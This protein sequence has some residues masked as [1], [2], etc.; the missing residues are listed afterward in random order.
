MRAAIRFMPELPL[1]EELPSWLDA[2]TAFR[3]LRNEFGVVFFDSALRHDTLGRYSFVS[4][5]PGCIM[6]IS[7]HATE[8]E[9]S[10]QSLA[11]FARNRP[12]TAVAGL[13]PFQ[14]GYIALL[15]YEL[16]GSIERVPAATNN[17]FA[18]PVAAI[19]S[20]DVVLAY[21]HVAHRGWIISH[22]DEYH[23]SRR[24]H[25][26]QR[27][28]QFKRFLFDGE[29]EE[30]PL[31]LYLDRA[32]PVYRHQLAPQYAVSP[33]A[34]LTS[35]FSRDQ[36]LDAVRRAVEYIHAGDIFQVNLSQ[37]LLYPA[38][39]DSAELYL[40]LR[41]R[42]PATFAGYFDIGDFQI[43]S[44]SPERFLSVRDGVVEARPIKGTRGRSSRPEA[45]LFAADDLQQ[46]E[47]DRAE[48]VMIVD[49]MRNDLAKV[50]EADS[51]AVT[52]LCGLETYQFV[53]HLVSVVQ[54]KLRADVS[55]LDVLRATF[56]GG[57][58]TGA[59][60]VRAMEI[61]AELEPTARGAYC[62]CVG[63]IGFDGTMDWNILIRTITA[64]RG[65]WQ[66][67]VG[68][69]IVAQSDPEREYEETWQKA[70]GMI[71]ALK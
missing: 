29:R 38:E 50:C 44:A 49:L 25:A 15:S 16:S 58:I 22:G 14:G 39:G 37:R 69:G 17:E 36:Y 5:W 24:D 53:Q 2:V 6:T 51:V 26:A 42:N 28:R 3:K 67:P 1:V 70:L 18:M 63:Y 31:S 13:P 64:G 61:I 23:S 21:D 20:Y 35:N 10:L 11:K 45:D 57:S 62:G 9:N 60:K 4:A 40:R 41:E 65:W 7:P 32:G 43:I 54:G 34:S 66:L 55:P 12:T 52:Q 30:E 8:K 56:P 33:I 68:G 71:K 19:G 47:K 48:N 27:L 46:S 59:P